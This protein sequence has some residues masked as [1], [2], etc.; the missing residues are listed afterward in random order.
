[1]RSLHS[2][3]AGS[4]APTYFISRNA[5][6]QDWSLSLKTKFRIMELVAAAG[7]STLAGY[8][9]SIEY[10]SILQDKEEKVRP[11]CGRAIFH[12]GASDGS[13]RQPANRA[14]SRHSGTPSRSLAPCAT[15][16][17]IISG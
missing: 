11:F 16:A 12:S 4:R 5:D 3:R 6:G 13:W 1:M 10:S 15:M 7:L 17:I 14:V 9:D 8:F 2:S